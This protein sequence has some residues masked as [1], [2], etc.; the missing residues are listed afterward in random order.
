MGPS[1]RLRA[2]TSPFDTAAMPG[3]CCVLRVT[4]FHTVHMRLNM[5]SFKEV[6]SYACNA[7]KR[8]LPQP[9]HALH[10][11]SAKACQCAWGCP[12]LHSHAAC[13]PPTRMYVVAKEGKGEAT[14]CKK[15][16]AHTHRH[17]RPTPGWCDV[18]LAQ[19]PRLHA[20]RRGPEA[21]QVARGRC[22]HPLHSPSF[23]RVP[24]IRRPS[25][26]CVCHMPH[27]SLTDHCSLLHPV[28]LFAG[29]PNVCPRWPRLSN[30]L[31][32][33]GGPGHFPMYAVHTRPH[34]HVYTGPCGFILFAFFTSQG[35]RTG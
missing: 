32:I 16:P 15:E 31:Q 24:A 14:A 19:R 5:H 22:S 30:M 6:P 18:G 17:P 33:V 34:H 21:P 23:S 3:L 27:P 20:A 1:Y 2:V 13:C 10:S 28:W 8:K 35:L 7:C 26:S 12:F 9:I 29:I 4:P 25:G 11:L